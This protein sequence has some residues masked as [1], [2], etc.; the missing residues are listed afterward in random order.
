MNRNKFGIK[1]QKRNKNKLRELGKSGEEQVATKVDIHGAV[2]ELG[3]RASI[4]PKGFKLWFGERLS[5]FRARLSVT[6]KSACK[7]DDYD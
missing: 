4:D 2:L 3:K 7:T 6:I 1:N 5:C